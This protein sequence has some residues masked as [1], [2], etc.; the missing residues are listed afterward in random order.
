METK[1]MILK[2][3]ADNIKKS[4]DF[5]DDFEQLK[6]IRLRVN[7]PIII[8]KNKSEIILNDKMYPDAQDILLTLE[9]MSDYSLYA[10]EEELK[11]GYITLCG[12]HRVGI[13]GKT[14]IDNGHIKTIK[15]INGLNIRLSH[16]IIGC[17]D[18]IMDSLYDKES[19]FHTIIISPPKCGKTTLLRDIVRQLSNGTK[20]KKGLTVGVVDERSEIGGCYNGIAQNDIGIRTD[21]LDACPKAEGIMLL[22]RSMSPEVIAVDEIGRNEDIYAIEEILNAGIKLICTVHGKT[23]DDICNKPVLSKIMKKNVFEKAIILS[24][25]K[26]IGTIEGIVCL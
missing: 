17:A 21:I 6:E 13:T 19:I 25:K 20:T 15:C 3:L 5:I 18:R 16:Q 11:N 24:N 14:I 23:L 22:L 8:Y 10:L 12:G 26:G 7:K 1:E 4:L 9:L 2:C